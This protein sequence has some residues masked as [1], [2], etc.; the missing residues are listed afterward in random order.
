M[1]HV[2]RSEL[3]TQALVEWYNSNMTLKLTNEMRHALEQNPGQPVRLE[4][5]QS[6]NVLLPLATY[7]RVESLFADD[8]FDVRD[9]YAAQS[10]AAGST[11]WD[12]AEMEVY[13][14]YDAHGLDG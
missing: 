2:L 5:E 8:S 10:G 4:D 3:S 14:N 7:E 6:H 1:W 11:G 9:T 12:D 13:D